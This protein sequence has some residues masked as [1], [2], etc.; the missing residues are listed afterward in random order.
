MCCISLV[1]VRVSGQRV[2]LLVVSSWSCGFA[3]RSSLYGAHASITWWTR[4]R[5][6]C[7]KATLA[8]GLLSTPLAHRLP[9]YQ[10]CDTGQVV[11][12][13][14]FAVIC[15]VIMIILLLARIRRTLPFGVW[16]L[17]SI[18]ALSTILLLLFIIVPRSL[19]RETMAQ[20]II[21][22]VSILLL[23]IKHMRWF[24]LL[25]VLTILHAWIP[26]Y[27]DMIQLPAWICFY[28]EPLA[29]LLDDDSFDILDSLA[30]ILVPLICQGVVAY[31]HNGAAVYDFV[32]HDVL[33]VVLGS[34]LMHC[35]LV[36]H[37]PSAWW[38][39][40][41]MWTVTCVSLPM[42]SLI[43]RMLLTA[44]TP[45]W[46]HVA[47]G[48]SWTRTVWA[49]PHRSVNQHL[50]EVYTWLDACVV[51][52]CLPRQAAAFPRHVFEWLFGPPKIIALPL[53]AIMALLSVLPIPFVPPVLGPTRPRWLLWALSG[54]PLA[55]FISYYTTAADNT[56]T[57]DDTLPSWSG[58]TIIVIVRHWLKIWLS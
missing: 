9:L 30:S 18:V 49:L 4:R 47:S 7:C 15:V 24:V 33:L 22:A 26:N 6:Y 54:V 41:M 38:A 17:L 40:V 13:T 28:T 50:P 48:L 12:W 3:L 23:I 51:G 20:V 31:C 55:C 27:V 53:F 2:S 19:Y 44:G 11:E 45:A 39:M 5:I 21:V 56:F 32:T 43:P 16:K 35:A 8:I 46:V 58:I 52:L 37:R 10:A 14:L 29:W 42:Q 36:A 34:P 1:L 57:M 25:A